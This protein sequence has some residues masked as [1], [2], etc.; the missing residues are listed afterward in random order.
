MR[1]SL[2]VV[3]AA[4]SL[5][6]LIQAPAQA[7]ATVF[8]FFDR[9]TETFQ[10]ALEGCVPGEGTV[11]LTETNTG[12]VVDTGNRVF[13]VRGVDIYDY[14]LN[15]PSGW[16]VQSTI[17]RDRFVFVAN[18][19]HIVNH[20]V[21]QDFRT[22]YDADGQKVGTMTIHAGY[23]VVYTDRNSNFQPDPGE[24]TIERGYFNL[25]CR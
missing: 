5:M 6:L 25:N 10:D 11:T 17:N 15:L 7:R 14:H 4:V 20:V 2:G 18:G 16:Y 1:R 9:H 19:Q 21:T 12:Q 22:I 3:I 13:S 24:V 8:R 23:K